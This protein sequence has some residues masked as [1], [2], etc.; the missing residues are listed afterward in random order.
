ML[1]DHAT[2]S[3]FYSLSGP[4]DFVLDVLPIQTAIQRLDPNLRIVWNP[5]AYLV[6][7]HALDDYGQA[8]PAQYAE[9]WQVV[10]TGRRDGQ[11]TIVHTL[12]DE[13]GPDK[14]YR[15]VGWW[16]VDFLQMWDRANVAA[17]QR[18]GDL[19]AMNDR[20]DAA[21][22]EASEA[23]AQD[24][25]DRFGVDVLRDKKYPGCGADFTP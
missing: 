21:A 17:V 25:V 4:Q 16:L 8:I 6:R 9:R 11:P 19:M 23:Q 14:P 2:T 20:L 5:H 3:G 22:R 10:T 7:P 1:L 18:L 15:A 12:G 24:D 13:L